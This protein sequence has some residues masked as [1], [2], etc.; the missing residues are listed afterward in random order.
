MNI[1]R[2]PLRRNRAHSV[3]ELAWLCCGMQ[4]L[5]A[6]QLKIDQ[7]KA[8]IAAFCN[9]QLHYC[10]IAWSGCC[11]TYQAVNNVAECGDLHTSLHRASSHPWPGPRG[12]RVCHALDRPFLSVTGWFAWGLAVGVTYQAPSMARGVRD[13]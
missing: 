7:I 12:I 11:F 5:V 2:R 10:I 8:Q 3:A 9:K 6:L 4:A 13:W 1:V